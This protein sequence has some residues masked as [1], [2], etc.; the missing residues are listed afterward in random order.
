L[1]D[2]NKENL[3][4]QVSTKKIKTIGRG[5]N[6]ILLIDCGVKEGIIDGLLR[7]NTTVCQIPWDLDPLEKRLEFNAVVV[8]NGPGDPKKVVKTIDTV[9]KLLRGKVPML[10]ICLGNQ[11]MAL[12]SGANT[13]KL[14]YGHRSHNQPVKLINSD[15]CYLT[16]Q[17]HGFAVDNKTIGKDWQAWFTNLNDNTNEGLR[18]KNLPFMSVQFHPE[19]RPGPFDTDWVFDEFLKHIT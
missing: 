11:I 7:R 14:K 6:K 8:S 19:G 1:T 18:H 12:A 16:T 5:K 4:D 9:K 2:P 15:K 13:Y 3:V 10:G 17:N